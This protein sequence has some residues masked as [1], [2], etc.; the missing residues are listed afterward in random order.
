MRSKIKAYTFVIFAHKTGSSRLPHFSFAV[1]KL[2]LN[3]SKREALEQKPHQQWS[4]NL[5]TY[6][7]IVY[8]KQET[9]NQL[10]PTWLTVVNKP[11]MEPNPNVGFV[12]LWCQTRKRGQI[13]ELEIYSIN[14]QLARIFRT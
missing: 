8:F 6:Y 13:L 4:V 2:D 14:S 1:F 7:F 12:S 3:S 5:L 9:N 11:G 10:F